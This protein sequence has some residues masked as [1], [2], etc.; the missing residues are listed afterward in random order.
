MTE[1][2]NEESE[3]RYL[4]TAGLKLKLHS[5]LTWLH[6]FHHHYLEEPPAFPPQTQEINFWEVGHVIS[7]ES[8]LRQFTELPGYLSPYVK[9]SQATLGQLNTC[10]V[11]FSAEVQQS[12]TAAPRG[13]WILINF[14]NTISGLSPRQPLQ[15]CGSKAFIIDPAIT[16]HIRARSGEG[17]A[18]L[19]QCDRPAL[20]EFS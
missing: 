12:L 19:V 13:V 20:M 1:R 6:T 14:I 18:V 9:T 5:A 15:R 16:C 4:T 3:A 11:Y 8:L 7:Q 10:R 2:H 17:A